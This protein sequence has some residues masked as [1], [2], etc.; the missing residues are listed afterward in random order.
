MSAVT[1][2]S[3]IQLSAASA[4]YAPTN[5]ADVSA[6]AS[7][8]A[9]SAASSKLD[10]SATADFYSTSNP[11]GFLTG[12]DLSD[13]ATTAYVDSSVSGKQD[14]LT[15]GYDS[16]KISAINGSALAGG[17][18]GGS[19]ISTGE[20]LGYTVVSAD[21]GVSV[22]GNSG[23]VSSSVS[24]PYTDTTWA[25]NTISA[26]SNK[27][28]F[29]I[30]NFSRT[31]GNMTSLPTGNS[32]RIRVTAATPNQAVYTDDQIHLIVYTGTNSGSP[33]GNW[34]V[35][36]AQSYKS[37]IWDKT[38][39]WNSTNQPNMLITAENFNTYSFSTTALYSAVGVGS[40]ASESS[41]TAD[42]LATHPSYVSSVA[43]SY[44]E[45][46]VS[47][48]ADS[49]ALSSYVPYSSL[50][51][52]TASAISGINGSA[53]AAGSTYSAGEGIDITDDVISVEAPV[54][55][56]A[57]PGIVIDNPD[58]NTLRVSTDENYE[59]VLWSGEALTG[60]TLSE[61]L[62]NFEQIKVVYAEGAGSTRIGYFVTNH[63]DATHL[64]GVGSGL[65]WEDT[66]EY[67][68]HIHGINLSIS[69]NAVTV[70]T[71]LAQ[72]FSITNNAFIKWDMGSSFRLLK[73]MGIHRIA[74]N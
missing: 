68:M 18:G 1:G 74:N 33:I 17:G 72:C 31:A 4:A 63:F 53:L 62:T 13:Y 20:F 46:A 15:F 25:T 47:G 6:I 44:A 70:V 60:I 54:D 51:Y 38:V 34:Q 28:Q 55:I 12:V 7:A 21:N 73:I 32:V 57:G 52:N 41:Y 67:P 45:S 9:E 65:Y 27:S 64:A 56:V 35:Q 59:T 19:T 5:S 8:Y 66:S 14:T 61:S 36:T 23:V 22:V 40:S 30:Y 49:S 26:N 37:A 71:A 58:G 10:E 50:E 43:S 16:N 39:T 11:S 42:V 69:N 48:K 29:R 3:G 2:I 24:I